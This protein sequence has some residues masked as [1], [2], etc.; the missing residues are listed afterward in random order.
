MF[1]NITVADFHLA[2]RSHYIEF[3]FPEE[4]KRWG[5]LGRLRNTINNLE[6]TKAY[7]ARQ[8]AVKGPFLPPAA[9]LNPSFE[10]YQ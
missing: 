10:Q 6:S 9:F 8:G 1:E 3:L 4:S 2:E 7:Y 5:F